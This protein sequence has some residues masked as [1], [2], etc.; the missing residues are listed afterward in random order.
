M[1]G[2]GCPDGVALADETATRVDDPSPTVR[3]VTAVHD[4]VT[5][6][7]ALAERASELSPEAEEGT[8][9]S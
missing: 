5:L 8:E 3:I 6:S 9:R 4:F 1:V 7:L 2:T